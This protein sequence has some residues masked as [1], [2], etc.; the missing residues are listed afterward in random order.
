[1]TITSSMSLSLNSGSRLPH[2]ILLLNMGHNKFWAVKCLNMEQPKLHS[3]AN[4]MK[5]VFLQCWLM[6]HHAVSLQLL[7]WPLN[8]QVLPC[9]HSAS[10]NTSKHWLKPLASYQRPACYKFPCSYY[11]FHLLQKVTGIQ[12][13]DLLL[14]SYHHSSACKIKWV[15]LWILSC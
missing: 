4:V 9:T 10:N 7:L 13:T 1:M 3:K 6:L 12:K 11:T 8:L 14:F 15:Y 2:G 5:P